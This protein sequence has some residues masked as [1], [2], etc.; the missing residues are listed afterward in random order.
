MA[1]IITD[2]TVCPLCSEILKEEDVIYSFPHF[3]P[4]V[5]DELYMFSDMAFHYACIIKHPLWEKAYRYVERFKLSI[6]PQNRKCSVGGNLIDSY[7]DY[8]FIDLLTSNEKEELSNFN[9]WVLD[10]RNL[11]TWKERE[12]FIDIASKFIA[13][14]KWEDYGDYKYL[15]KLIERFV[16]I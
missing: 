2:K 4:N 1:I 13:E 9:F 16:R 6:M 15:D 8:I 5:K 11:S 3:V 7:E 10:R 14:G 12:K